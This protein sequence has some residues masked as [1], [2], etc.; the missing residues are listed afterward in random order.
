METFRPNPGIRAAPGSI[1]V[2]NTSAGRWRERV[3]PAGG[4]EPP[5]AGAATRKLRESFLGAIRR[6]LQC[7][8]GHGSVPEVISIAPQNAM[9]VAHIAPNVNQ[10][11]LAPR[12]AP[13]RAPAPPIAA[14]AFRPCTRAPSGV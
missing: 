1:E 3:R 5:G 8:F 13:I 9:M 11:L 2:P 7:E 4:S 6:R 12:T 14:I 10:R